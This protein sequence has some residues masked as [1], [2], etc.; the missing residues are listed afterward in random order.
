MYTYH[1]YYLSA[2]S[3][4]KEI[5]KFIAESAIMMDFDHP[6]ILRLIGVCSNMEDNLPAIV[7]P[8]MAMGDLRSFLRAKRAAL[9]TSNTQAAKEQYPKVR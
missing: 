2:A 5:E 9:V 4:S 7:L 8:Y 1:L 6:N 3:D